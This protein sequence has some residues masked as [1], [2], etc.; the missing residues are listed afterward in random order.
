[1][2]GDANIFEAFNARVMKIVRVFEPVMEQLVVERHGDIFPLEGRKNTVTPAAAMG[3]WENNPRQMNSK[4]SKEKERSAD[5]VEFGGEV[6]DDRPDI[7]GVLSEVLQQDAVSFNARKLD[8]YKRHQMAL[9]IRAQVLVEYGPTNGKRKALVFAD[10]PTFSSRIPLH[11]MGRLV[12]DRNNADSS[13]ANVQNI[14]AIGGRLGVWFAPLDWI[15]AVSFCQLCVQNGNINFLEATHYTET[16]FGATRRQGERVGK[17]RRAAVEEEEEEEDE[18]DPYRT[19]RNAAD[20]QRAAEQIVRSRATDNQWQRFDDITTLLSPKTLRDRCERLLPKSIVRNFRNSP[21]ITL[22]L[23][24]AMHSEQ[25]QTI[26]EA[27]SDKQALDAV[28]RGTEYIDALATLL[29]T[30]PDVLCVDKLRRSAAESVSQPTIALLPDLPYEKFEELC[31]KHSLDIAPGA[32]SGIDIYH[33]IFRRDVYGYFSLKEAMAPSGNA[34][35]TSGHMFSVL[36]A[37]ESYYKQRY[38][39]LET[40]MLAGSS[41]SA[42]NMTLDDDNAM[43]EC[44]RFALPWDSLDAQLETSDFERYARD[45]SSEVSRSLGID[46]GRLRNQESRSRIALLRGLYWLTSQRIVAVQRF[47]GT[48]QFNKGMPVDAFTLANVDEMQTEL[49]ALLADVW[50]RGRGGPQERPIDTDAYLELYGETQRARD[51]WLVMYNKSVYSMKEQSAENPALSDMAQLACEIARGNKI[52][53]ERYAQVVGERDAQCRYFDIRARGVPCYEE[54]SDAAVQARRHLS[55]PYRCWPLLHKAP[56]RT[57]MRDGAP[58]CDEQVEAVHKVSNEPIVQISG[59]AGTGKTEILSAVLEQYPPEQVLLLAFT[60][61]VASQLAERTKM[62]ARTIHSA[63]L[64]HGKWKEASNRAVRFASGRNF[65]RRR[66]RQ[67]VAVQFESEEDVLAAVAEGD[68]QEVRAYV[69]HQIEAQPPYESPFRGVRVVCVDE[70]SLVPYLLLWR[71]LQALHCPNEGR[72]LEKIVLIGDVDQ[73]PSIDF[74]AVQSDFAHGAPLSIA[75]LTVNHRSSG[76][77]LFSLAQALAEHREALPMPSFTRE[78]AWN[79]MSEKDK[80]LVCLRTDD[81]WQRMAVEELS[82]GYSSFSGDLSGIYRE[83][84]AASITDTATHETQCIA[85]TNKVVDAANIALGKLYFVQPALDEARAK[86]HATLNGGGAVGIV[87]NANAFAEQAM[88]IEKKMSDIEDMRMRFFDARIEMGGRFYMVA[89]KTIRYDPHKHDDQRREKRLYNGR[90]L[91][92]CH[93]YIAPA[94]LTANIKCRCG[95]CPPLSAEQVAADEINECMRRF[96]LVPPRRQFSAPNGAPPLNDEE[97]AL[98]SAAAID[99]AP[100]QFQH[101]QD[102]LSRL[103]ASSRQLLVA[104]DAQGE[105]VELDVNLLLKK[106]SA[107]RHSYAITLHKVQGGEQQNVVYLATDGSWI[108]W[109]YLYTAI[110]RARERCV[111]VSDDIAFKKLAHRRESLRRSAFWLHI[112]S[113]TTG[114]P[115]PEWPAPV[116]DQEQSRALWARFERMRVTQQEEEESEE[117]SLGKRMRE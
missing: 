56:L 82:V 113:A 52:F 34:T 16:V 23:R 77:E 31:T 35:Y 115:L 36:G 71:L 106:S 89:N 70:V 63:L 13:V 74:G 43:C 40:A 112:H 62:G 104:R 75:Q 78:A 6:E 68:L 25:L 11:I 22:G 47:I 64:A 67:K 3:K 66:E 93:V 9:A 18:I 46:F 2:N 72:F 15:D 37:H 33:N 76:T 69:E 73:L 17:R 95:L 26:G 102:W 8:M 61:Q 88:K 107:W 116:V 84:G 12:T 19:Y 57:T 90:I 83:L 87:R 85:H 1:M 41:M 105:Y 81:N 28:A 55:L 54:T 10:W 32:L 92:A 27:Y 79:A 98:Q 101:H 50:R 21:Y 60:G 108:T 38:Y 91:V 4:D 58:F 20:A 7:E 29:V 42:V 59:R 100:R 49:A 45:M 117:S 24:M 86:E 99:A 51:T 110:T 65:R 14:D 5:V 111:I 44:G 103:D 39:H 48:G 80:A 94:R 114:E 109:K 53:A 96:D 97:R 30:Q